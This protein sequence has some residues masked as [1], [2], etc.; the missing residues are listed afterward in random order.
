[1][2]L[3]TMAVCAI[4]AVLAVGGIAQAD[5]S[6]GFETDI[7]G[8]DAF[9]GTYNP[10]RVATGS[11]GIASASGSFHAEN[12]STGS[13]GNWGGYNYGAGGGVP[14]VFQEY[15]TSVDIYLDVAG[16]WG[17]NTRFDFSSAINNSAGNHKRDFIFNGG[18]YDDATGPGAS[19]DRFVFSASNTS[20]P[21][22][23]YPKNPDRD[24]IAIDTT[25]WY[26][27]EHHFYDNAGVLAVDM[28]I[29][30]SASALVN[31]WTLSNVVEDLIAGV[32]GNRYG[33]FAY[34]EFS[35]LAFDNSSLT[36]SS[37]VIPLPAAAWMGFVLLGGMG[38]VRAIRR[39]VRK[40]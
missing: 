34:N 2:K 21:G 13:A 11:N 3:R 33:W 5:Y 20:Q 36:I 17:N 25:G 40:A 8:W 27:F 19:T 30:D 6:N 38:G 1:M 35:V 12:S 18:F 26:T 37:T 31:A 4:A 39:K 9:G 22:D 10:T 14:T 23:A 24:P 7:A 32:G 28:S 29:Y 15:V 16:G